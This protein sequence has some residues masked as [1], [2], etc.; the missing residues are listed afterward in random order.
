MN[1]PTRIARL[2]WLAVL[3]LTPAC[4]LFS[5][6]PRPE[7]VETEVPALSEQVL[8]E[9]VVVSL[10]KSGF[11]VGAGVDPGGRTVKT[12]WRESAHA[13]KSKGWREKATVEYAPVAPGSPGEA[14]DTGRFEVRIRVQRET[15]ESL[16]PLDP[17]YAKWREASDYAP[18]AARVMQYVRSMLDDSFELGEP[19]RPWEERNERRN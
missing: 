18:S 4:A 16:R 3:L 13:F 11:P 2:G 7:W 6:K 17:E 14:G 19:D 8:R 10:R 15:N 9:V 1:A 12:G 5:T